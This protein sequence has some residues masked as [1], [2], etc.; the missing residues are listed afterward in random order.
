[1]STYGV[2]RDMLDQIRACMFDADGSCDYKFFVSMGEPTAD[3]NSVAAWLDRKDRGPVNPD[4]STKIFDTTIKVMLT[5]CCAALDAQVE[6]STELE[7]KEAQCFLRDLD[8]L[9]NCI[10]CNLDA[11][12]EI[13]CGFVLREVSTDSEREGGCYSATLDIEVTEQDCCSS[14]EV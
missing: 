7:Q 3:C 2:I 5:R 10:N 14:E 12:E 1:M 6:F 8:L 9:T 4:C 11:S 13:S